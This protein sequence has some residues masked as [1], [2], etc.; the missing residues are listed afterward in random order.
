MSPSRME[1]E[2]NGKGEDMCDQNSLAS[3]EL[4]F[5]PPQVG[6]A[7]RRQ[8]KRKMNLS[9]KEA[10]WQSLFSLEIPLLAVLMMVLSISLLTT[11]DSVSRPGIF[12]ISYSSFIVC[13]FLELSGL[14][15][16][17]CGMT[18]SFMSMGGLDIGQAFTFHPLGPAFYLLTVLAALGLALSLAF[19]KRFVFSLNPAI[20]K[21]LIG[22]TAAGVLL[23]WPLKVYIWHKTGLL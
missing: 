23:A 21:A 17:F 9:L 2:K 10:S 12:N 16:L 15:C 19:K 7:W 6:I 5:A 20:W 4:D 8:V 22:A 3:I 13:P 18:R 11:P 14:P 1:D